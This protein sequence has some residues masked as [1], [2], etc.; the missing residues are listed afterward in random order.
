M[1]TIQ[2]SLAK[3]RWL[4]AQAA[5]FADGSPRAAE[6]T[7]AIAG[8]ARTYMVLAITEFLAGTVA[9]LVPAVGARVATLETEN[10]GLIR[11]AGLGL[12]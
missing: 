1:T 5:Q 4:A 2:A 12:Q 7:P 3:A 11:A 10:N 9:A 8:A 6:R